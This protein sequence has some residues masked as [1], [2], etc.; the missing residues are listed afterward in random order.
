MQRAWGDAQILS[1][2]VGLRSCELCRSK[3]EA[4][5]GD[6]AVCPRS[7]K[8]YGFGLRG[9][10]QIL[11]KIVWFSENG[12]IMRF[13]VYNSVPL[14]PKNAHKVAAGARAVPPQTNLTL[15]TS[16]GAQLR[17]TEAQNP[18]N[19]RYG[20]TEQRTRTAYPDLPVIPQVLRGTAQGPACQTARDRTY[21][22]YHI[23]SH[24]L[25][26][27]RVWCRK[28][29]TIEAWGQRHISQRASMPDIP[30]RRISRMTT[31]GTASRPPAS[32]GET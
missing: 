1:A 12:G 15:E 31:P 11:G 8:S 10:T 7:Q 25:A 26:V 23:C 29:R 6:A 9:H 5:L 19:K 32:T 28:V 16:P 22:T 3:S 30:V 27:A 17:A 18:G 2:R 24:L 14:Q 21:R 20:G 4:V 13:L